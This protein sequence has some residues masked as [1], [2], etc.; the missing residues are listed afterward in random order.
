V[1]LDPSFSTV[2]PN[3]ASPGIMSVRMHGSG[4][5]QQP[6]SVVALS[7]TIVAQD[8]LICFSHLRW[9]FVYQRPQHL[10]TRFARLYRV[11]FWEEPFYEPLPAP[12]LDLMEQAGITLAVPVLPYDTDEATAESAQAELL[13]QLLAGSSRGRLIFWY[14]TPMALGFSGQHARDL[15]VFDCMDELS[16]F[17]FAPPRLKAREAELLGRADL[18]FTGGASL[19]EAKRA[20]HWSVHAF[21]SSINAAHF[22]RARR[23]RDEPADQAALPRPRLGYFGVVDERLDLEL[24]AAIADLRPDWQIVMVGPLA[25]IDEADLPRPPNI[26]WLGGKTYDELPDYLA[27]WNVGLMPFALNEA[28]RFISPTKT[29]EFLAA[30]VPVVS[31]PIVD[32]VRSYGEP[33]LVEIAATAVDMVAKADHL[34]ARP[35]SE[36]LHRVDRHLSGLSWD[37]TWAAMHELMQEKLAAPP[38]VRAD[39]RTAVAHV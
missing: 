19:Y 3:I 1:S 21:P 38:V 15:C 25:K 17:R 5:W 36:W 7:D 28:T 13:D 11:I 35:K 16:A 6:S 26:H 4:W 31:T 2:F 23:Q 12:R 39:G 24:V 8:T 20:R 9:N 27:G 14:Y 30:G 22:G 18:V 34:L 29:P 10:M 32:V 37:R 33:G